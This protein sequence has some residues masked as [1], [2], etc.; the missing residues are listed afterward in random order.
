MRRELM[1]AV[2]A[3]TMA[4]LVACGGV[5]QWEESSAEMGSQ[6]Q[7]VLYAPPAAASGNVR[8]ST[9]YLGP[10][11]LGGQVQTYFTT[12][13]QYYSFTLQSPGSLRAA[14]EVT[15][16]GSSM[17]LD[18]GLFVYGPKNASG[19][20]GSAP[21]AQDDDSGYGELSKLASVALQAGEYLVVVSSGDGAGK[22]FRLQTSC[23]SGACPTS[24][25]PAPS[26]YQLT[27]SEQ[28]IS[29]QLQATLNSGNAA[30]DWTDGHLRRFDFAWPYSGEASLAQADA[31]IM[32]IQDYQQ[33]YS[34]DPGTPLTYSQAQS[35][36][37]SE[38]QP[39]APQIL[40]TYGNGSETV[41]VMTHYYSRLVAPGA[42]G[43]FRLFVILFPQSKKIIVFEQIG[44]E[45]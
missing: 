38:Y 4:V 16:G 26:G 42:S 21:I 8:D 28:A 29:A 18:T 41:Q 40:S 22:Q 19:S 13:P 20:Y 27:L 37:Y 14:L 7:P 36:F 1:S 24:L 43:W 11:S 12:N 44:Y 23:L 34:T 5:S 39:L 15:H 30:Q 2:W 32:G 35:Y 9:T 25:P 33:Y 31:A 17:S 10:V 6:Q 3:L 45:T